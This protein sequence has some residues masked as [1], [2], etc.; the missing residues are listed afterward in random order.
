MYYYNLNVDKST[1]MN[2]VFIIE[3]SGELYVAKEL[4]NEEEYNKIA[5][6]VSSN[7]YSPIINKE[8]SYFFIYNE[9]KYV[10]FK[11]VNPSVARYDNFYIIP[12]ISNT[13]INYT[14]IWTH[15]IEYFINQ[16]MNMENRSIEQIDSLNYYIGMSENAITLNEKAKKING[17]ARQCVSHYRIK[18]P[19]YN[20]TYNDPTELK[21]DYISRDIA[22]Y[23]KSKFFYDDMTLD[24]FIK[25]INKYQ[26]NDKELAFLFA[27]LLYPN[28]YFDLINSNNI[29]KQQIIIDKRKKYEEFLSDIFKQ[30]KTTNLSININWLHKL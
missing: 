24:E 20:L 2:N 25:I 9:K 4:K 23:T 10:L 14:D 5:S 19:N 27:R 29:D 8:G 22:E 16:L 15:N 13:E 7:Y 1:L 11:A 30:I 6:S 17:T 26:L 28:Y 12:T 3:S 21:V 18:Y